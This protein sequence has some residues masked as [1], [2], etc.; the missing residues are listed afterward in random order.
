MTAS[1]R[2]PPAKRPS[3]RLP[4]V[5]DLDDALLRTD[6]LMETLVAY[7]RRRPLGIACVL[8]WLVHGRAR[9][10]RELARRSTF[11]AELWPI[12]NAIADYARAEAQSA[13][14][15]VLVTAADPLVADRVRAR[16]PFLSEVLTSDGPGSLTGAR[17][18]DRLGRRFADGF[19][20]AGAAGDR[21]V[22]RQAKAAI[23]AGRGGRGARAG[24]LP[25]VEASFVARAGGLRAWAR[26]LRLQQ[27]AKNALVFVP[28]VLGG[29]GS[30][31]DAWIACFIAFLGMGVLASSS[32]VVND[33]FDLDDDRKHWSKR[34]RPF[35]SGALPLAWG[36]LAAPIG[37]VIGFALAAA[38]GSTPALLMFG[39]YLA[40][41]IA[42]SLGLKRIPILDAYV[43]ATLFTIRLAI[44][45]VV[46]VVP[47]SAW[48]L[49][50]SMFLFTSLSLA[51]RLTET[52]RMREH[53]HARALGRDY[54]AADTGTI[55]GFGA[56]SATAAVLI[57][58]LYLIEEAFAKS[59]YAVPQ[60]LWALPA[61]LAIWLGR[62]WLLCGRGEL[63]DDPVAF[64]VRDP[65]SLALGALMAAALLGSVWLPTG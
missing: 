16:F 56:A 64:A 38:A 45:I 47:P 8:W 59:F 43:L 22:W 27:W 57:F 55:A 40:T 32:Y 48:L 21:A 65:V 61:L 26:A 10:K 28:L 58:V 11:D 6:P 63:L 52:Q 46:A 37:I 23:L 33:L 19:V 25:P 13:R 62:V 42:Y 24:G 17:R 36:I 4:L 20:Y 30:D 15:V 31:V 34:S 14:A 39:A 51:K 53:G 12:N 50:F 7:L 2:V 60:L 41:T 1:A 9:L 44:G 54:V 35:A 29:K 5:L 3:P 49:V 18:A